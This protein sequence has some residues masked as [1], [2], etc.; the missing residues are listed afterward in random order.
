[1]NRYLLIA[2][3]A[4]AVAILFGWQHIERQADQLAT[5]TEQV[6]TLTKAAESRRNT[7]RLLAQL[8]TEHTKALTDAKTANNQLRTAV[9]TGARRLSVKATCPAVRSATGAARLDDAEAR[10]ELDPAS[11]ER[12]VATATDGDEAIVALTALQDYVSRVCLKGN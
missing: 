2:L 1:M 4:C 6:A 5:A 10:A 11:A 7:Q 9:A 8:D 3:A 12:I